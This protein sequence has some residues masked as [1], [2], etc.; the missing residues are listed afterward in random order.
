[1]TDKHRSIVDRYSRIDDKVFM[2]LDEAAVLAEELAVRVNKSG[3]QANK[4]IGVAN[5]ALMPATIISDYLDIPLE[6]L[7]V[8]RKGSRIKKNLAKFGF[9]RKLVSFLYGLPVTKSVLRFTMDRFNRLENSP[10][11]S[12]SVKRSVQNLLIVDDA[13]ESGQTLQRIIEMQGI[14]AKQSIK[15]AVISWSRNY[16]GKKYDC[17]PDYYISERIQHFPWSQNSPANAEY[18]GWLKERGIQEWD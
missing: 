16:T 10:K 2:T 9:L 14:N 15:V 18:L 17:V 5:G 4:V 12:A 1:M 8:R 13:I 6:I 11:S 3:F 7:R